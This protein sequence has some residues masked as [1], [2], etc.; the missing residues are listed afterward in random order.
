MTINNKEIDGL[1]NL[2][3]LWSGR[4]GWEWLEGSQEIL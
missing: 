1:E 2:N 4:Q 3:G